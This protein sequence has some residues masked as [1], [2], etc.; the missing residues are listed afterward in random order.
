[1]AKTTVLAGLAVVASIVCSVLREMAPDE[2][3]WSMAFLRFSDADNSPWLLMMV[4]RLSLSASACLSIARFMSA[5]SSISW[6]LIA[7][8]STPHSVVS[9]ATSFLISSAIFC[10]SV[11]RLSNSTWPMTSRRAVWAYWVTA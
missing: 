11:N 2:D 5:G 7:V 8:T 9:L 4:A 1:M 10:L 3:M 6:I